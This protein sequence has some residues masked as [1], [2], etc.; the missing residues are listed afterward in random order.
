MT[1][2]NKINKINKQFYIY[3]YVYH[4]E[5][6]YLGKTNRYLF[7]R[8]QEHKNEV[9]FMPYLSE[10]MIQYYEPGDIVIFVLYLEI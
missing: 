1:E 4:G 2:I 3:R 8:I 9:K 6:I 10:V 5:I 7:Y